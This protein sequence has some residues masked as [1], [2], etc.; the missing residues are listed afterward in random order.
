MPKLWQAKVLTDP[1]LHA[2]TA[3]R[4]RARE[5]SRQSSMRSLVSTLLTSLAAGAL[6]ACGTMQA[7]TVTATTTV[8]GVTQEITVTRTARSNEPVKAASATRLEDT[9]PTNCPV[10]GGPNRGVINVRLAATSYGPETKRLVGCS[11]AKDLVEIVRGR[12]T[13][14]VIKTRNFTCTGS[15]LKA[16][17][18]FNCELAQSGGRSGTISYSF[19]L[20]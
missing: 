3:N 5:R 12:G 10:A 1:P 6:T 13:Y 20:P 15:P 16:S 19:D 18:E 8:A 4:R 7:V 2:R 9:P 17:H 14:G 11:T